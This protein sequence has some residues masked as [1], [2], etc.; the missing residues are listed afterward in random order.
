MS[1][2]AIPILGRIMMELGI[3]KTRIGAIAITAAAINDVVGWITLLAVVSAPHG[4]R[5]LFANLRH[6]NWDCW[7]YSS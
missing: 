6:S 7:L 2:T 1:I 5:I 3:T 4:L